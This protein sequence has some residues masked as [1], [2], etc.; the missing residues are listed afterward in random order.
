MEGAVSLEDFSWIEEVGS[1]IGREDVESSCSWV[2][3]L[4][5]LEGIDACGLEEAEI[6]GGVSC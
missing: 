3:I 4:K 1:R 6:L 2:A 5:F